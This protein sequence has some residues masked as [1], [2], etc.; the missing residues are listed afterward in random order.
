MITTLFVVYFAGIG[1]GFSAAA[2]FFARRVAVLE[3]DIRICVRWIEDLTEQRHEF[4]TEEKQDD[5]AN[6]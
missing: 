5:E 4:Y 2:L 6:V 3:Q 1:I